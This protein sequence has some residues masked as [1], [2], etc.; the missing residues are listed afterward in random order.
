MTVAVGEA[1][2]RGREK[3]SLLKGGELAFSLDVVAIHEGKVP[4]MPAFEG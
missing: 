4:K 1:V 2:G 3:L